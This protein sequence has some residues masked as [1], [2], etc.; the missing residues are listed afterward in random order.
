MKFNS[1][2]ARLLTLPLAALV[3]YVAVSAVALFALD[4]SLNRSK[5]TQLRAVV[6]LAYAIVARYQ[7]QEQDG[8]LSREVAQ[9]AAQAALRTLRYE[10]NEYFWINDLGRPAPK[11]LMHPT[12]PALEGKVL[13]E[14]RFNK[15][16]SQRDVK[17]GRV[18]NFAGKNLFVAFVDIVDQAGEGFVSYEWPKPKAG[19]GVT[20]ELYTKLSFV[21]KFE[22]WGWVIGSGVYIDDLRSAYWDVARWILA[23]TALAVVVMLGLSLLLRRWV[24]GRLGGEVVD[25]VAATKR[26]GQGDLV[27]PVDVTAGGRDS[28]LAEVEAMRVSLADIVGTIVKNSQQLAHD[29]NVLSAD[30]AEMG[31]GLQLQSV[32]GEQVRTSV[33]SISDSIQMISTLATET[34]QHARQLSE[35]TTQGEAM[36]SDAAGGMSEISSTVQRSAQSVNQL[37]ARAAE[38]GNIVGIIKEIAD[39]TNLLALNAAI[40]AARAGEQGRGFAVVADEVR[41]LAER[42][43]KATGDISRMIAQVQGETRQAVDEMT[44]VGPIVEKGVRTAEETSSLLGEVRAVSSN[45]LEKMTR[46][47]GVLSEQVNQAGIIVAQVGQSIEITRKA[48][49]LIDATNKV[50]QRAEG[51]ADT[52]FTA[53]KHFRTNTV[54]GSAADERVRVKLLEWSPTLAVGIQSIDT[55]HQRLIELCNEL[56]DGLHSKDARGSIGKVLDELLRYTEYHFAHEADL[57]TKH[58]YSDKGDHHAKHDDLVNKALVYKKRFDQGEAINTELT[59]FL[60]DWLVN[61]ILRTDRAMAIELRAKGVR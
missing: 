36:V 4:A 25:A 57:M 19:G 17:G 8:Q 31:T 47:A 53:V 55:Q 46:L 22:P 38:I 20:S 15:A 49:T 60:R 40:E 56:N 29:M 24:L 52:L 61:H 39:Q 2:R 7:K 54:A 34:E 9:D 16:T 10:G 13:D 45:T 27:T 5:E 58:N 30:S 12:V 1:I 33:E 23:L 43:A 35:R 28:L 32:S 3:G 21:K 14:A 48:A 42:T 59:R 37:V 51:S 26:I 11:M 6:D 50:A 41:K 18:E 44:A